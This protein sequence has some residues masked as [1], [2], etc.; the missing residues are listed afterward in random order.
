LLY[1]L[2]HQAFE[3]RPVHVL[4]IAKQSA[5]NL[6]ECIAFQKLA[7]VTLAVKLL[8]SADSRFATDPLCVT[9]SWI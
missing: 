7:R 1:G 9:A 2:I 8:A 3:F 4:S 6:L 5:S